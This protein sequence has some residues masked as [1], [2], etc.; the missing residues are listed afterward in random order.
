MRK[1]VLVLLLVGV[2]IFFIPGLRERV[3]PRVNESWAWLSEKL[4]GP[5]TP[6]LTPYWKLKTQSR[7]D[8]AVPALI[9]GRNQGKPAPLPG[10][11]PEFLTRHGIEPVDAWGSEF[12]LEQ[13]PDSVAI[14]SPGPDLELNTD[15]DI[16]RKIRYRDFRAR[17]R[18]R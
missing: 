7:I 12:V 15:D 9:R 14:V 16:M 17:A 5:L 2:G 8:N 13:E 10:E 18:R 6:V 11:L 4:E 1:I 3:E